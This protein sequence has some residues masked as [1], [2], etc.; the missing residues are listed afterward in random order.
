MSKKLVSICDR[1]LA[2]VTQNS[3]RVPG[4]IAMVTNNSENIYE[5]AAGEKN[6]DG[7]AAMTTDTIVCILSC[8]KAITGTAIMQLV[9]QG[10]IDLDE[11]AKKYAPKLGK[12]QVLAGFD[13][14][15]NPTLRPPK[16][17]VTTRM[18]MLHTAGF[19]Y[20]FFNES[21]LRLAKEQHLPSVLTGTKASLKAPLVF[22]PGEGWEYGIN[23]DWCGQIVENITGKRLGHYMKEHI[24]D[25][26]GMTDSAFAVS[27]SMNERMA[28]IHQRNEDGSLSPFKE[29]LMPHTPEMDMGG[30]GLYA[31]VGDYMRFIRMILNDG[32]G[33][34]GRVL[35]EDTVQ[36]MAQNGLGTR[37]INPF[38]GV[39]PSLSNDAEFFPGMPKSWAYTFMINDET[40][41]TGRPAG[42]LGWAGLANL[43]YW[44]DR[45]NGVGG[46]WA[47]QI[48]PFADEASFT[49]Y[50]N[51][52]TSVYQNLNGSTSVAAKNR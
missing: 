6:L 10:K 32:R 33:D 41:P 31:T 22:D 2:E 3:L 47:T 27:P 14:N 8:T 21:Y 46:F 43:F 37:K 52:E 12:V 30:S 51:L 23:M 7:D 49:G 44:I 40:A 39:I 20:D 35:K 36:Q 13:A 28:V 25:P 5:G 16:T 26:L 38:K 17:D 34:N 15:G 42:S 50:I 48:L 1:I 24:F 9:E 29:A 18:L 4:V 11:P 45:L 19:S